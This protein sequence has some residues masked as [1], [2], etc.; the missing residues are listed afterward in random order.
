M[1]IREFE[2]NNLVSLKG[3]P[4]ATDKERRPSEARE[5]R[6]R[7]TVSAPETVEKCDEQEHFGAPEGLS[8]YGSNPE[9][10]ILY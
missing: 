8:P 2:G 3:A 4:V 9:G 7:E 10:V 5:R 6:G 1:R